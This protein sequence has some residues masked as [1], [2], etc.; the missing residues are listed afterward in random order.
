MASIRHILLVALSSAIL[1]SCGSEHA[2]EGAESKGAASNLVPV[3]AQSSS[4]LD[5]KTET[6]E[7]RGLANRLHVTGRIQAEVSK[8][9]DVSPRFS[10]RVVSIDVALGQRVNT[11]NV[12]ARVDSQAVGEMQ[13]ELIEA[14]SKLD[15]AR[16]HEERERQIYEEQRQRPKELLAAQADFEQL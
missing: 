1:C 13:A 6:V 8:E 3:S 4:Q 12:L 9:I 2:K 14:Q 7:R 16:A 5:L 11:G 15:I 10:G